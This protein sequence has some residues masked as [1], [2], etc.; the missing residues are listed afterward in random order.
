MSADFPYTFTVFTPAY[1]RAGLLPRAY[2]SLKKQTF[3]DFEWLII[4]DGSTD[5]TAEVVKNWQATSPFPIRYIAKPNGGKH[6]AINRGAKEAQGR[7]FASLDSDD[8][9][10]PQTLERFLHHWN[11]I[12]ASEQPKFVGVCAL[13]SRASGEVI[14]TRFP[15]DVLDSDPIDLRYKHHVEGDKNG[16]LRTEILRQYPFPEDVGKFISESIVWNRIAKT[17]QTRFVNEVLTVAEYQADGLSNTGKAVQVN[18]TRASLLAARELIG[19]GNRLPLK[20][21]VRAYANYV[22]H[23]LHQEIPFGQQ[24][25]GAPSKALF[26]C[27]F[28]LGMYLKMGDQKVLRAVA[29]S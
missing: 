6:T 26:C 15:Q 13:V 24:V 27:C 12:A 25:A 18:N 20:P 22:R 3:K 23:S 9:Y 17:Y 29:K 16:I 14:G 28:P 5:N 10:L 8:W 7:L 11:T 19:L 1:N 2:E 21:R 4:D